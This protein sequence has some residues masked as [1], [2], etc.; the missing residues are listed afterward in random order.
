MRIIDETGKYT[1]LTYTVVDERKPYCLC[2][3]ESRL[4]DS[5]ER[6]EIDISIYKVRP[7][8][9]SAFVLNCLTLKTV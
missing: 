7:K 2:Q 8:L 6:D 9:I 1:R 5:D 3:P 4:P